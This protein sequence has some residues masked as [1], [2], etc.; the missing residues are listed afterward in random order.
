MRAVRILDAGKVETRD[1]PDPVPQGEEVVLRLEAAPICGSDLH[2][3]YQTPGEKTWIPGHEGAGVVV[4]VDRPRVLKVGDRVAASAVYSCGTCD[5]CRAGYSIYCRQPKGVYGFGL[6]GVHAQYVRMSERALLVMPDSMTFEQAGLCL[7]PVGTPYHMYKRT[8][9]TAM[10][11]VGVFGAGP[12]GL[13][14]VCVGAF[15]GAKVIAVEPVAYRRNLAKKLGAAETVDPAAG[16]VVR[17]IRDLT[18]GYGLD[19]AVECSGEA[20]PL[21]W[22]LELV[23]HFGQVGIIGE[24][25]ESKI[26]PSNHFLRKEVTLS[27]ST[28]FPLQEFDEIAR[29][30]E[31]GMRAAEMITHRFTVDQAAEAYATFATKQTGKCIFVPK[32]QV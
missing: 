3:L 5:L 21:Y 27:G 30:Y 32:K 11:V 9:T 18:K 26:N 29:M 14:A 15:L 28:C 2:G 20:E 6:N 4:A 19:R 12:M 1:Y 31:R 24:R 17:Q 7:D 13:G 23:R 10:H 16:D 8:Q 22:A 25:Q